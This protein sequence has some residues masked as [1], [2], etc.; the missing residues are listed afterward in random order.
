MSRTLSADRLVLSCGMTV[1]PKNGRLMLWKR[2]CGFAQ[3]IQCICYGTGSG[4]AGNIGR[5]P[6]ILL[7]EGLQL[8]GFARCLMEASAYSATVPAM[9]SRKAC[10]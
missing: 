7:Q 2:R 4:Y 8:F 1:H 5:C 10:P 3:P 6:S 9:N